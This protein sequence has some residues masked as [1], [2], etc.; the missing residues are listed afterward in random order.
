[1]RHCSGLGIMFD[2]VSESR[3]L[4]LCVLI[5]LVSLLI[6]QQ[7]TVLGSAV[8]IGVGARVSDMVGLC[9]SWHACAVGVASAHT[10]D[11]VLGIT[12]SGEV[13]VGGCGPLLV[14]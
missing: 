9:V 12:L 2:L 5:L 1:M 8:Q 13:K 4:Q 14:A 10:V 3:E 7:L 11:S 6:W